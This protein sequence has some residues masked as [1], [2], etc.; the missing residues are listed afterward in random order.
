MCP[1]KL[2][3]KDNPREN[4]CFQKYLMILTIYMNFCVFRA[5]PKHSQLTLIILPLVKWHH[6]WVQSTTYFPWNSEAWDLQSCNRS[7][8]FGSPYNTAM[9][10]KSVHESAL[11]WSVSVEA[12]SLV[13]TTPSHKHGE[14][15]QKLLN[16][17]MCSPL[18][19]IS[20]RDLKVSH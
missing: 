3:V 19:R 12:V 18:A 14:S 8:F 17:H 6:F 15:N 20:P 10:S 1:K 13:G 9:I 4:K 11:N 7:G 16:A 5:Q 2:I